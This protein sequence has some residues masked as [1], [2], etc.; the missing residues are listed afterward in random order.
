MDSASSSICVDESY[1]NAMTDDIS[2]NMAIAM[3]I[4]AANPI[5]WLQHGACTGQCTTDSKHTIT[6]IKV[7]TAAYKAKK[8]LRMRD[9]LER[10]SP[11][12]TF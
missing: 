12:V 3:S 9:S 11:F 4:W 1:L 10:N 8:K 5:D 6:N 2:G 7:T